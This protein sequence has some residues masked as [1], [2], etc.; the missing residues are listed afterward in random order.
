MRPPHRKHTRKKLQGGQADK[1]GRRRL[2]NAFP[3]EK[4]PPALTAQTAASQQTLNFNSRPPPEQP[5]PD[6]LRL[7]SRQACWHA[8][9]VKQGPQVRHFLNL[10]FLAPF[11]R[12][13]E[14]RELLFPKRAG[15]FT[16]GCSKGGTGKA[17]DAK[18]QDAGISL[19]QCP[20]NCAAEKGQTY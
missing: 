19:K 16:G 8:P 14:E 6:C 7:P 15:C 13:T 9:L 18:L 5:P 11:S 2:L 3:T 1:T 20:G 10:L 4:K 12:G 17:E